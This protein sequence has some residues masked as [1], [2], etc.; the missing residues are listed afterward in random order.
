VRPAVH[1]HSRD[2]RTPHPALCAPQPNMARSLLT[3]AAA[4]LAVSVGSA[5]MCTFQPLQRGGAWRGAQRARA[6][7]EP[8]CVICRTAAAAALCSHAPPLP[9]RPARRR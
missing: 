2:S 1:A 5:H 7:S 4:A 6:A 8:S 3:A 9:P